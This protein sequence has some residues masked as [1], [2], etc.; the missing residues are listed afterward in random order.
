MDPNV[1]VAVCSDII[2]LA[3]MPHT[4]HIVDCFNNAKGVGKKGNP[5]LK[6]IDKTISA[7]Q[8]LQL[9]KDSKPDKDVSILMQDLL[10]GG[11]KTE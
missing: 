3:S 9:L 11:F 6:L 8:I 1:V 10:R 4:C 2:Q 5:I 7:K